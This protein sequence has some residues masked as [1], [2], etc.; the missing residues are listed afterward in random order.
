MPSSV[1]PTIASSDDSTIAES[2]ASLRARLLERRDV[3]QRQHDAVDRRRLGAARLRRRG[4]GTAGCAGSSSVPALSRICVLDGDAGRAARARCRRIS[5]G[6]VEVVREVAERP[7]DVVRDDAEDLG[8][9]RRELADAQLAVEE[10]RADVGA[11]EQVLDV[12]VELLQLGVLLLVLGVDGVELLVDRVQL[13]V[14][15]LQLLVRRDQLLVG[16][17]HL[18]VGGLEL[19]DRRLQGLVRVREL[20]L[21]RRASRSLRQPGRVDATARWPARPR[22]RAR[23]RRRSAPAPA[24]RVRVE[25]R[26]QHVRRRAVRIAQ[27][28]AEQRVRAGAPGHRHAVVARRCRRPCAR[29]AA[30]RRRRSAARRRASRAGSASAGAALTLSSVSA[31]PKL[32][33]SCPC[34]STRKLGGMKRSSSWS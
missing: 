15:A 22:R 4:R 14:R 17:L 11:L 29:A 2:C 21:E 6:A 20:V 1:L 31:P 3:G 16:R 9:P 27:R 10:Q 19:L 24:A 18:L 7:A 32:S 12:V 28:L 23:L 5:V 26:D 25:Q 8:D 30:R 33:T 34:S 13:L